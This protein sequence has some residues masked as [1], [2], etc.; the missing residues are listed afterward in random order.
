MIV[1]GAAGLT[2][3]KTWFL[4]SQEERMGSC[5][6]THSGMSKEHGIRAV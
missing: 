3:S 2:G 5:E 1:L 6:G 4:L